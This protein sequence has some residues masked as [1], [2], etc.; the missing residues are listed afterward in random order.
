MLNDEMLGEGLEEMFSGQLYQDEN[1]QMNDEEIDVVGDAGAGEE[2]DES[3]KGETMIEF[4]SGTLGDAASAESSHWSR[5][6]LM[7]K[8]NDLKQT[9]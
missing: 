4:D 3:E 8:L 9:C 2:E 5:K 6:T 1:S 7:N